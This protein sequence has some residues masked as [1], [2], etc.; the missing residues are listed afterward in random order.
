MNMWTSALTSGP[1]GVTVLVWGLPGLHNGTWNS[2]W[3]S[4]CFVGP[5]SHE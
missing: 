1:R 5:S 4:V 3:Q 2:V